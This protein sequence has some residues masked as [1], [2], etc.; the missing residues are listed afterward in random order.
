M[1]RID[2]IYTQW[3]F[4]GTRRIRKILNRE[5][6]KI[7]RKK[8]Q[9]FMR[10]MGIQ[11]IYPKKWLSQPILEHKKY[12][13]LLRNMKIDRPDQVWA[14]DIT[15]IRLKKGFVYLVAIM[16]WYS[17]YVISWRLS[18]TI[19]NCFCV[20][21]LKD[22]LDQGQPEYFNTDQGGQFTSKEFIE[23]LEEKKIK[24]SMDSKGRAFDNIFIERLWWSVK[25]NDVYIKEYETVID[26]WKGL[27]RYFEF[28]NYSKPHQSL[29]YQTPYEVYRPGN[30]LLDKAS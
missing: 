11:A 2:E 21:A 14:A 23:P 10:I 3:P 16:D 9:R 19:E 30:K 29:D 8:V 6:I 24:I 22:A 18:T 26:L 28:H 17:R 27:K 12:P 20:E 4:L 15:Y 13:Y 5:G 1:H 7:N 25:Y